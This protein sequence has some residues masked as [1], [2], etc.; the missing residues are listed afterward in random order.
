MPSGAL[1]FCKDA[2][3]SNSIYNLLVIDQIPCKKPAESE[4]PCKLKTIFMDGHM[5][6]VQWLTF[7][8]TCSLWE[9]SHTDQ[10]MVT[11]YRCIFFF[12]FGWGTTTSVLLTFKPTKQY[13]KSRREYKQLNILATIEGY[14]FNPRF[15]MREGNGREEKRIR[16]KGKMRVKDSKVIGFFPS[17]VIQTDENT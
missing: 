11:N 5:S 14:E 8:D 6:T 15:G 4:W 10:E 3:W 13:P 9:S 12:F 7:S 2:V 17:H 16:K 1:I